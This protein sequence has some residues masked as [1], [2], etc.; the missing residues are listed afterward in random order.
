MSSEPDGKNEEVAFR[1]TRLSDLLLLAMS[2]YS[3]GGDPKLWCRL[4][5]Q[6]APHHLMGLTALGSGIGSDLA[7]GLILGRLKGRV[8]HIEH[9]STAP[10]METTN[11]MEVLVKKLVDGMPSEVKSVQ[12]VVDERDHGLHKFISR[13]LRFK[14]I[15]VAHDWYVKG[16][17]GIRFQYPLGREEKG[18]DL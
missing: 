5:G 8:F 11:L 2:T 9:V 4:I 1:L 14:A 15:N 10:D 16:H 18:G 13:Q 7:A 3:K 12:W 6:W 17:H